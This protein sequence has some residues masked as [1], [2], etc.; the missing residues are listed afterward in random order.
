M[1]TGLAYHP[2]FLEHRTGKHH[3]EKPERLKSIVAKLQAAHL[4]DAL[5]HLDVQPAPME[6]ILK[7][8]SED[9]VNRLREACAGGQPNIDVPDS[10]ICPQSF[11]IARLA[12]GAGLAAADAV[13]TGKVRN[14]FCA[15]R[16]PGHHAEREQSMGF[17]LFAN[18]AIL[19]QYILERWQQPR[20]AIVDWDVHHGNGTQHLFEDR[21][22]V[23]FIS[24]HEHPAHQY[25]G[26]G[27]A[28]ET[29][30]GA[31]QGYTINY[32][33]QP[34]AGDAEMR[35][36]FTTR[37]LPELKKF[38]P[39]FL[40]MSAGFDASEHDPLGHLKITAECFLWM[41]RQL[42]QFA[43]D[44]CQGRLISM[45]EG[46]YDLRALAECVALHV[47]ALME[48]AGHDGMMSMKAGVH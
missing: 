6:W 13:M 15:V 21:S 48:P 41:T 43:D 29:G 22:D 20:I 5:A 37:L 35:E 14:A 9:Y 45:L 1:N 28:W 47:G 40:L 25:P 39:T 10:A 18:I 17:C 12:V 38:Q 30:T 34:G 44:R 7:M 2:L 3:P 8:H 24:I 16:P 11:E 33:L 19:S 26:T 42:K 23:L 4:W 46:G 27:F 36:L 31:G 32:P